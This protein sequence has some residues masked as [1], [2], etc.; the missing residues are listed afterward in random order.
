MVT[1]RACFL[2][3]G[4]LT[5]VLALA[6]LLGSI[7]LLIVGG[8]SWSLDRVLARGPIKLSDEGQSGTESSP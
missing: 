2:G 8:G 7:F 5:A 6:A 3:T 4:P 1:N